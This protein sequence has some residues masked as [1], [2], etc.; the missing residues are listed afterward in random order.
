MR[1]P[2]ADF[3]GS[4]WYFFES[5][6][7]TFQAWIPVNPSLLT[8][9][10]INPSPGAKQPGAPT[11]PHTHTHSLSSS[12]GLSPAPGSWRHLK[13][14]EELIVP[15]QKNILC[16]Y[17]TILEHCCF[18]FSENL[19]IKWPYS[20]KQY[21]NIWNSLYSWS[22]PQFQS[23]NCPVITTMN[24]GAERK[25]TFYSPAPVRLCDLTVAFPNICP[26]KH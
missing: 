15:F 5:R 23:P 24:H 18:S 20:L 4:S 21:I 16:V 26:S 6:N 13:A 14:V 2:L 11:P 3:C 7:L 10:K 1:G 22:T 25:I 12:P 19:F 9:P 17:K 8:S